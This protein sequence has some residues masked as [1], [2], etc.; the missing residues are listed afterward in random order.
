[1]NQDIKF[2]FK[3][4]IRIGYSYFYLKTKVRL[5]ISHALTPSK[6]HTKLY[7][8]IQG[9]H[10]PNDHESGLTTN[11][12]HI[13]KTIQFFNNIMKSTISQ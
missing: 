12:V 1:M 4:V 6:V 5:L 7:H 9:T 3:A 11:L 13:Y 2:L 10:W 8:W